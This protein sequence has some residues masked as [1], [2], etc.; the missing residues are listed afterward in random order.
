MILIIHKDRLPETENWDCED[1]VVK[2]HK[3]DRD[4]TT[5]Q[6]AYLWS[7]VYKYIADFTGHST[8]EIH[9][10]MKY[11]LLPRTEV[12]VGET[13]TSVPKSTKSLTT[14]EFGEYVD[15]VV[16]FAGTE[17]GITIPA[18]NQS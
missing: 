11:R 3:A 18:P 17:L 9:S 16:A 5:R 13:S 4:R 15:R 7:T 8:E 1:V 6:N 12:L 2:P 14:K 10:A